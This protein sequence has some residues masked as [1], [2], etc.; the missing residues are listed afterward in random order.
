MEGD[1]FF[2]HLQLFAILAGGGIGNWQ[3]PYRRRSWSKITVAVPC[4][5][6]RNETA[7]KNLQ[8]AQYL[9]EIRGIIKCS[10]R[11]FHGIQNIS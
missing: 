2:G 5:I 10:T 3:P 7:G 9:E 4:T 6:Q 1:I 8:V 11:R